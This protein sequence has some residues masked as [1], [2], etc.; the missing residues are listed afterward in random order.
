MAQE[1]TMTTVLILLALALAA[2]LLFLLMQESD[3]EVS[4]SLRLDAPIDA[5]YLAIIDFTT[6][7][8]WSP[9]LIH[10]PG[11]E[12]RFRE[13]HQQIGGWYEWDGKLI[14][15]GR[16]THRRQLVNE[17]VEQDIEFRRPFKTRSRVSWELRA[18][19]I[20]TQVT[21]RMEGRMPLPLRF[22]TGMMKDMIG[23]DYD[24]G[25]HLLNGY[26]D[27]DNPHPQISFRG[28]TTMDPF[29]YLARSFKGNLKDMQ[30]AMTKGFA[31][32]GEKAM[33]AH[34]AEGRPCTL[35][36]KVDPVK[37]WFECD[38]AIPVRVGSHIERGEIRHCAGGRYYR[39]RLKG[40]YR[41]LELAWYKAYNH[42]Q[43]LGLK[44]DDKRPS[45]ECY[46]NDLES[47]AD[48]RELLTSIYVPLK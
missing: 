40:D 7:P 21:W 17:R 32:L 39:V 41:F 18:E 37:P 29:D 8:K 12:L 19:G 4:R 30:Q 23:H 2:A 9:W 22:M 1:A 3:Y 47:V 31:E 27:P 35:Y 5:V 48:S 25:L 28:E 11:A 43:M 14:G 33:R 16:L 26:L 45:L 34:I 42:L 38:M 13:S 44:V 46:D 20:R 15:A 6:W 24:L 10:E 36:F